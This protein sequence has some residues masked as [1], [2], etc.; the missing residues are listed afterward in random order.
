MEN[1]NNKFEENNMLDKADFKDEFIE[2]NMAYNHLEHARKIEGH[3]I[4]KIN[5]NTENKKESPSEEHLHGHPEHN[6]K[7]SHEEKL[8][9]LLPKENRNFKEILVDVLKQI[10][11]S[12]IILV[13]GF[14]ILN[15][16][17]YYQIGKNAWNKYFGEGE[18]TEQQL[19]DLTDHGTPTTN[20]TN[21]LK[22]SANIEIQKK[23]IP[24]LSLEIMPIDNRIII[25][26]INKNLPMVRVS[27]KNLLTKDWSALEKDMQQA[28]ENGVVH[29]P[30]TSV[31]GQN[32]NTVITGHSS[33]FPWDPG[34][35]KDVFALL[36]DMRIDDKIVIY[37][38]QEKYVYQVTEK[39][40][41]MPENI[42]V[43]KQTPEE[44]LTLITCTPV[45]T[46]L[47]RLIIVAKRINEEP[48]TQ[49]ETAK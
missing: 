25:P 22:T 41:V 16:S 34:R 6:H 17:A 10:F 21:S 47:R 12:I 26:R 30:G 49:V 18:Q 36:H 38:E 24:D 13:I 32:G 7:K 35:F 20:T 19:A 8:L 48:S 14:F 45:G 43:L 23:Q 31:P 46:N 4:F 29:Y 3:D 28:L 39:K 37:Y 9:D 1:D 33:Y 42:D 11:A 5:L 44:R 15:Y 40:E 2:E 27:S